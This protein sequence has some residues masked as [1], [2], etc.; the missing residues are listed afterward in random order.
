MQSGMLA[1]NDI[2]SN[3]WAYD[4]GAVLDSAGVTTLCFSRRLAD[5][6]AKS[7]PDLRAG[8]WMGRVR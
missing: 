3:S 2:T 1:Q 5:S 6:R 4:T 8:D 7:I